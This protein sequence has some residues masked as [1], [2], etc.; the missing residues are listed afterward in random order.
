MASAN[1][2]AVLQSESKKKIYEHARDFFT[3]KLTLPLGN[4]ELKKVHTNQFLFFA[5]PSEFEL[6]NWETLAEVLASTYTRY[7]NGYTI[8]RWYVENVDISV[9]AKGKAEMNIGLNAFSS[10]LSEYGA[11]RRDFEKAYRD[12]VDNKNNTT[13]NN[14]TVKSTTNAV[15]N[16]T[17]VIN[18]KWVKKYSIP[19]CITNIIKKICS[20]NKSDYDN[21]RTWF[22]WM[23]KHINYA[24]YTDHQRSFQT[25]INKGSGNC[26]DNSR[27]FRAGCL[28]MGIKCNFVKG[29]SCCSGGECANHQWNKVYIG[30]K[31]YTVDTGR[32]YASWGSHWGSCSGG[33]KETTSSW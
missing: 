2:I 3:C 23:D 9:E 19:S 32:S 29:F 24:S 5:L 13:K 30:N 22:K 6:A 8:N 31:S 20:V 33:S 27:M 12:A 1:D 17:S 28:A 15:T 7:S 18:E 25:Q 4:T 16:K 11:S 10:G 14:T 21:V 26:V